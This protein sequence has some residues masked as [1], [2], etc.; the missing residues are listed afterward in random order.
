MSDIAQASQVSRQTLYSRFGDKDGLINA[1]IVYLVEC[2]HHK[3]EKAWGQVDTLDAALDAFFEH[4]ITAFYQ[5]VKASPD[6]DDLISGGTQQFR[7]ATR[8]A[9][10]IKARALASLFQDHEAAITAKGQTV[11]DLAWF[12]ASAASGVKQSA[13]DEEELAQRLSTLKVLILSLL[14]PA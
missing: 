6:S 3:L 4:M 10:A 11:S 8:Q 1:A 2:Q 7:D 14:K 5:M 12:C 13:A 9:D